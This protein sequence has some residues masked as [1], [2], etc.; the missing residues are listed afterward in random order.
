V[1]GDEVPVPH[2]GTCL[3]VPDF[4]AFAEMLGKKKEVDFIIEP[5]LR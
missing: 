1:D 3:S 4:L 5:H 2:F